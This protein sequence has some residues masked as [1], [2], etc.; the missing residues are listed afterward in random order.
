MKSRTK[1]HLS[2]EKIAEL[3]RVNFGEGC[4]ASCITELTGGMFNAVYLIR[5]KREG[6]EIVLKVGVLPDTP[7]LSYE[8]D[9]MRREVECM[10]MISE[11]TTVPIPKV[12][13]CDFSRTRIA[14]DYF[15]MTKVE[16]VAFS[17]VSRKIEKT[18][19][20]QVLGEMAAYLAQMHQVKGTYFGYPTDDK[21][22][23]FGTWKE[24]FFHMYE[25]L[26]ADAKE[27][28]YKLPYDRIRK[29]LKEYASYLEEIKEPALVEYDCHEGNVFVKENGDGKW[30]VAG[31]IDFERFFWGDPIAD[32]T[33][34][35]FLLPDV[36][37]EPAFLSA[38]LKASRE[39][40][41]YTKDDEVRYLLYR[42]YILT[43]MSSEV[44]RYGRLYAWIQGTMGKRYLRQSMDL[45]EAME[46]KVKE[47]VI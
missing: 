27:R 19:R 3:L 14:G 29:I 21:S 26:L 24:A 5:R 20:D 9:L 44:F 47:P 37:K 38:Y 6:D 13:A 30:H 28:G 43:I 8:K 32:F 12:L 45:L 23:Q 36:R 41:E 18:Q 11:Q 10:R 16:G 33:G 31:I 42:M 4:E 25:T 7:H 1:H 34:V 40:K 17:S 39:H 46:S 35:F 22:E 15:F 2:E